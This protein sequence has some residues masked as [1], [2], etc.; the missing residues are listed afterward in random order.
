MMNTQLRKVRKYLDVIKKTVFCNERKPENVTFCPCDYKVGHTPPPLEDFRPFTL[1]ESFGSGKDSHAWFH[2]TL[3]IPEDMRDRPVE[4]VVES[5]FKRSVGSTPQFNLYINGEFRQ[6]MDTQ[7]TAHR[8]NGETFCDVYIYAYTGPATPRSKFFVSYRNVNELAYAL[9]YDLASPL[10]ALETLDVHSQEYAEILRY[11]DAAVSKLDLFEVGSEDYFRSVAEAKIYMDTEFYGKYCKKQDAT[12]A[13]IGHTHIDCAWLWSIRQTREK[14]QRS[15]A[16]VLAL[17]KRYP[18]YKFTSSQPLLYKFM[19][20]EAP[21]LYEE[22]K[23]RVAEGRWECEGAM[24][25]EADC[26]LT[27]G[28]SLVRQIIY[29]KRFFREEFGKD[30]HILWL[31][32]VFGYSAALP[33][34]LRKSGVDWFVTSKIS[35]NDVNTMP[36]DTFLWEGLDGTKINT[37]FLTA[38]NKKAGQ[39]PERHATYN[40]FLT[41]PMLAGTWHRYQQKNLSDE[42]MISYGYGDGGGGPT[43]GH[44]ENASRLAKGIPGIPNAKLTFADEFLTDL[45]RKIEGNALLPKWSGELYLEYHR[46]TYTSIAKNKRNNRKSEFLYM[47]AEW[48]STMQKLLNGKAFPK[49][50]LRDGWEMILTNQFHDIIPGSSIGE[51]YEQSDKDYTALMG[52][53]SAIVNEA[54]TA[55]AAQ[56]DAKNGY[57]VFNPNDFVGNGTVEI[58]GKCAYVTGIAPKGYTCVASFK[59]ENDIAIDGNTVETKHFTVVFDE[60]YQIVSIYDKENDREVIAEGGIGN[61]LRVYADHPD[62]FDNWEWQEYSLQQQYKTVTAV[63]SAEVVDD[64]VRKGVRIVRPFMRSTI[65][66][67]VWFYDDIAKIDFDTRIDWHQHH[68]MVKAAFA[69]DV[70]SDKA[71]Y[72]IQFGSVERPTH[73]NTS[74]DRAKFE[75]C[76]HKYA[77]LSDGGYGVALLNDCKYGYDIH[78]N[79]MQ[80]SLLKS[81][82]EPYPEADQGEHIFTYSLYPHAGAVKESDTVEL[83]YML[84]NPMTAVKATGAASSI[85]EAYSVAYTDKKNVI[86]ETVKEAEDSDATVLRLYE[87]KNIRGKT[88]LT[89]GFPATACY[90][91]D[92]LEN[93]EKEL[94][95]TDGKIKLDIR[96]FEILTLK[97]K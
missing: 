39:E 41:A 56:I 9:Y 6:G 27:A 65:V 21:A 76:A 59:T 68:Q 83:A 58:D 34:I 40:A 66:Q 47:N 93:E 33:Q 26:N 63:S 53:G 23:K 42:V 36:Y 10:E 71:T 30:N 57:V 62:R 92:M 35:W 74:W 44:L 60:N 49:Q 61:E 31:P 46:G 5:E 81:G 20:E 55:I 84:N 12:V 11:L 85:P 15:F 91:C 1:G 29:G 72:E 45:S 13:C 19:K 4:L 82:T 24:W 89:L 50:A 96:G 52:K 28:E 3:E 37:Y 67:T 94:P 80:L 43:V 22:I 2:F 32:D 54:Q 51:V 64:G 48:L 38:Q 7:H 90:L 14:V 8:L 87:C 95:I 77:D 79:I 18:D 16:T 17:M 88:T 97:I 86:V 25:V 78:D 75:V 70:H 69:V 73:K